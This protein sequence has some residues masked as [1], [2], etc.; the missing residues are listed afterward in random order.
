MWGGGGGF[1]Y[2]N[3]ARCFSSSALIFVLACCL[4]LLILLFRL[5][6]VSH[7]SNFSFVLLIA[8][9]IPVVYNYLMD[10]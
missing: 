4:Y 7:S 9:I 5:Y 2:R 6:L 3:R 8:A 10:C 1:H